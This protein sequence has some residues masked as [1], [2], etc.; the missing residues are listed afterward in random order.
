MNSVPSNLQRRRERCPVLHATNKCEVSRPQTHEVPNSKSAL[1]AGLRSRW[2]T[3]TK[4][5][6]KA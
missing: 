3:D 4:T 5:I 2:R 6:L 1:D